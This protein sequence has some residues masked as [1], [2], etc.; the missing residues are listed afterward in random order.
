MRK[1]FLFNVLAIIFACLGVGT[2]HSAMKPVESVKP[3]KPNSK[4]NGVQVG[5]ITYSY[6]D[7]PDK[8]IQATL[9][10]IV[11]SGISSVELMGGAVEAY[12]GLPREREAQKQWRVSASMDK[13]KEIKKMFDAKGVKIH[14]LKLETFGSDEEIDYAFKVAN[15]LGAVG[16]T[17]EVSLDKAKR[18]APFAEKHKSHIIFHNHCQPG[19]PGFSYDPI[20]AVSKAVALNFDFG[21]YYGVTGK[22]PCDF[23]RQYH[24]RIISVHAKDKTGPT[25]KEKCGENRSWGQGQ[26]PVAEILQCIQKE[27]Y[28]IYFDIELEYG[29]PK[30]SDPVKEVIKCVKYAQKALSTVKLPH[31]VSDNMMFQREAPVKLWGIAAQGETVTVNIGGQT[32]KA[33]PDKSGKWQINLKPLPVGGPYTLTIKGK[34]D[35]FE[36]GNILSG[37]IW[38]CGGQSNMEMP[39]AGWGKINDYEKEISEA[40]YPNIRLLV[41]PNQIAGIPQLDV[42][43]SGWKECSPT[44]IPEFSSVGYFFGRKLFKEL[45]IPIGLIDSN[46]GG[47]GVETW[48]TI[49][50]MNTMPQYAEQMKAVNS[51]DF[52]SRKDLDNPN[53]F[54]SLLYNAMISPL[55]TYPVKGAIWYQGEHNA[56]MAQRYKTLFPN[57]INDWR[58]VWNQPDMPF[59]FVQLAN[60]ITHKPDLNRSLAKSADTPTDN[61]WAELREAQHQTLSLPN[62]GEAVTID[63]GDPYDIHPKNKQDVGLRLA[64]N[65]LAKTYGKDIEYSG[66]EYESLKIESDKAILTFTHANGMCSK[67]KYGYIQG[68]TIAGADKKFY[69]AKAVINGD[70]ITV[71]SD[72]V[73]TP[74][75]VRYAWDTYPE[76]DLTNAAGLPASPFR[77][78]NWEL[79]TAK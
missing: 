63:I 36:F 6:R 29:V 77:T 22:N 2:A 51:P 55:I 17:T 18:L 50:T 65:A 44:S 12:A 26:T 39:L 7:M 15:T 25:E 76:A 54:P 21:H 49:E 46:W 34:T 10:Y 11:Q 73:K 52:A 66:P 60:F 57:M 20:L 8:S 23:I 62:T 64:L 4:F 3:V 61:A 45:N 24:D 67:N 78:D 37:D 70:K 40:N 27:K 33:K 38:V 1:L 53:K 9:D 28:P 30:D 13:F 19:E 71:S 41:V 5:A 31:Y 74:V 69:W 16:I 72:K 47:T 59:Y 58:R 42:K 32:G 14:I 35:S 48:T 68:F 43:M 75:A 79:T 56:G